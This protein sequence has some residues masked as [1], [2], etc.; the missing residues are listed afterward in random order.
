MTPK[1]EKS[2]NQIR[3]MVE[4]EKDVR[5]F[6]RLSDIEDIYSIC[7][8]KATDMAKEC[9]AFYKTGNVVLIHVKRFED[10][11]ETCRYT[12]EENDNDEIEED[13]EE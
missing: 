3:K 11:L 7:R 2:V 4:E 12:G 1:S 8:N 10:Y 13:I 9:G 5:K 6:L